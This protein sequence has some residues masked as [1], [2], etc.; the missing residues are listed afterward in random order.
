MSIDSEQR[1][2]MK[3]KALYYYYEKNY[4]QI[5]IAKILDISRITLGKLLKEARDEGMVKIEIVDKK[6]LHQLLELEDQIKSR[7][8]LLD[9]KVVD[10]YEESRSIITQ[11]LASAGAKY[12]DHI[13]RSGMKL[14][15][16]WGRTLEMTVDSLTENHSISGI[17]VYTLLG[18]AGTSE[19]RIQPNIIAERLLKKVSGVGY[20]INAPFIC[21]TRELCEAI[22]QEPHIASIIKRSADCDIT[23]AGIGETPDIATSRHEHYH[24]GAEIIK[25]MQEHEAVGDICANFFDIYGRVCDTSVRHRIVS[26]DISSLHR[27]KKV[28]GIGGGAYKVKSIL[29]ALNGKYLHMLITD[30]FTA[31]RVLKLADSMGI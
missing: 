7:F 16:S 22:K 12:L 15:I 4:T 10:C 18:G 13:L 14:G 27:H 1:Y 2:Y 19:S 29:G 20:I 23:L 8:G 11:N 30:K 17:E 6:N 21:R 28:I 26:I 9:V 24:Y 31:E 25:E 3:L 5:E